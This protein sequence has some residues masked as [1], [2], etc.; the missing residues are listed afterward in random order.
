LR[1]PGFEGE[2]E[3]EELGKNCNVLMCKR[4]FAS[5]TS[6]YGDIPFY[7][8]GTIGHIADAYISKELF[9]EYRNKYNYPRKGELL[10]TC[11]GT[12]GKCLV[13]D[14][15][16]AYFQDSNI[17]W[18][19]NPMGKI[20][21]EFLYYFISR[22]NW[23][24]LNSTTIT[25]IYNDDL[26]NLGIKFPKIQE[27]EKIATFLSLIDERISTQIKIIE[28]YKSLKMTLID[29]F[30]SHPQHNNSVQLA[31]CIFQKSERNKNNEKYQV[32]SVSNKYGFI[33]QSEQFENREVASEDVSNY[34]IVRENDFAYNP[35]RINVGSVAKLTD[36]ENGIVSPMYVCFH[37]KDNLLPDFLEFY[38]NSQLFKN[39]MNKR[40]E[41]SVR[42]CLTFEGLCDIPISL[43]PIN[44]Q[45]SVSTT[46]F[47]IQKK[48]NIENSVKDLLV[49]Q[50]KYLLNQMF[51]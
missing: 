36:Y 3:K 27:Q 50:K 46:L 14:G 12:V 39:E 4:I 8:I 28:D 10:I 29:Y 37:T 38:F 18:V 19:D 49:K 13:F 47:A 41:G 33:C 40:L 22:V 7:K 45:K 44:E 32:L 48:I 5:Q 43:P 23:G 31:E 34:K 11:A 26:R 15:K 1:F 17:V 35:A 16:D 2:W 20:E 24:K 51:I 21:N 42:Q 25:R 30:Y 6:E 9:A